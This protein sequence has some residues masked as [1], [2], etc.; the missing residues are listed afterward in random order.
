MK[1]L[2]ALS[3]MLILILFC[4]ISLNAG[5]R[6]V[7]GTGAGM[8]YNDVWK[9]WHEYPILI[10]VDNDGNTYIKGGESLIVATGLL[11]PDERIEFIN[12][13]RKGL[14]W[15]ITAKKEKLEITKELGSFKQGENGIVLSFNASNKGN[16][17]DIILDIVDFDKFDKITLH[18]NPTQIK[19][20]I[21]LLEKV[22]QTL[23]ELQI[24]QKK[25]EVLK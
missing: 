3:T 11:M 20:L 8:Y 1:N 18:L 9:T 7:Q 10:S 4:S 21:R 16:K 12:L 15:V 23:K 24:Y 6:T 2:F 22:P 13:L 14:E 19:R 17:T 5:T 25:S